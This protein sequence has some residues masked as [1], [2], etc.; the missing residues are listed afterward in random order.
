M[1]DL[2]KRRLPIRL[3]KGTS[4]AH[5]S[6]YSNSSMLTFGRLIEHSRRAAISHICAIQY[7]MFPAACCDSDMA[8]NLFV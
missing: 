3:T 4:A 7:L 2:R 6:K 1:S 8:A 5:D